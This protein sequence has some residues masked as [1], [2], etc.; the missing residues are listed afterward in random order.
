VKHNVCEYFSC[1]GK[2]VAFAEVIINI[3]SSPLDCCGIR[4]TENM[5]VFSDIASGIGRGASV[6]VEAVYHGGM[7][8]LYV[9]AYIR[10]N[11]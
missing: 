4:N 2:L 11:L 3:T 6:K 10:Q 8:C 7:R 9:N 5:Y 1:K